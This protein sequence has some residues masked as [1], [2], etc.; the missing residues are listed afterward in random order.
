MYA[1]GAR[2][3]NQ[4]TLACAQALTFSSDQA[5]AASY[6]GGPANSTSTTSTLPGA[7]RPRR[8]AL[9][10]A[11]ASR[12]WSTRSTSAE[13]AG[14]SAGRSRASAGRVPPR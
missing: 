8:I 12:P 2:A 3:R 9:A 7:P 11:N 14:P 13:T 4:A 10:V 5:S 1:V 6:G